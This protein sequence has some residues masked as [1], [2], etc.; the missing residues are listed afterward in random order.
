MKF[1]SRYLV[2]L[3][4]LFL[5][6][7]FLDQNRTPVPIKI[8]IGGPFQLGLSLIIIITMVIAVIMTL[9]VVYAMKKRKKQ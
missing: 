7:V 1:K 8:I 9:G 5:V 6:A 3:M 2:I 4:S